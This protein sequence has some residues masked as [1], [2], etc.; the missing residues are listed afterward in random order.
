G[1]E[2]R[3]ECDRGGPAFELGERALEQ[4][5]GRVRRAGVDVP[6]PIA[7]VGLAL[8]GRAEMDRRGDRARRGIDGV[9]SVSGERLD[10]HV[11]GD[12]VSDSRRYPPLR[13]GDTPGYRRAAP[14]TIL[15]ASLVS[16]RGSSRC[17]SAP[18]RCSLR[19]RSFPCC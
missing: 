6:L 13:N 17:R 2:P 10:A 9:A 4:M 1:G 8:E 5:P 3:G 14:L 15:K 16:L 11:Y 18:R 19:S 7:A 12:E